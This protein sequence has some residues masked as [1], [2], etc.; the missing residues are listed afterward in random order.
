M[1]SA[2]IPASASAAIDRC[3]RASLVFD[4]ETIAGTVRRVADLAHAH[5]IRVL[6]AAKSFPHPA[7][8]AIAAQHLD[9]FD[10][11]SPAE[12]AD[13][14]PL[15]QMISIADPSGAAIAAAASTRGQLIVS[16]ETVEHVRAAPAHAAIALRLSASL[17]GRDPAI[18]AV[19]EGNGHHRSRFGLDVDPVRR[20]A[21][22]GELV[23]AAAGR[24]IGLHV[25]H[26]P[27]VAA[28][29]ERFVATAQAALAAVD[30]TPSFL[31]LGGAWHGIADLGAAF[32]SLRAAVPA[33][34]ELVVEPGRLFSA[35][36][37]F[38]V[39]RVTSARSLDDR[40]LRVLDLSRICHLRWS[41]IEL[42]ARAP[43]AGEGRAV[44]YA[45]P[46]C[47]EEDAIGEWTVAPA[48][49]AESGAVF[50]GVTGYALA[51]NVGFAGVRP[52]DVVV[53]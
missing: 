5:R 31:N 34:I 43:A 15:A 23:R 41:P 50:R 36:A 17:T 14:A 1:T 9:G 22:I 52:A 6:F 10:V 42:V 48:V 7:V 45:G 13:C 3:E 38:A 25:H 27:I 53:A 44:L 16:C 2:L 37:G 19:L 8:R 33:A 4:L 30:V 29:A 51:W 32:A 39:G 26:G 20:R 21:A 40:E 11:A 49:A 18:G 47:F 24:P 35:G 12:L 28:S 46:T